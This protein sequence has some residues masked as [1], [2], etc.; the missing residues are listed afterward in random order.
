MS[1]DNYR[2]VVF[3]SEVARFP[4]TKNIKNRVKSKANKEA[5]DFYG[6]QEVFN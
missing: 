5:I 3:Q 2:I 1:L 4:Y 6:I